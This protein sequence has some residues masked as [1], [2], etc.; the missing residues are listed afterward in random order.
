MKKVIIAVVLIVLAVTLA[1]ALMARPLAPAVSMGDLG[2]TEPDAATRVAGNLRARL[3]TGR[4][5]IERTIEAKKNARSFRMKTVLR[6]DPG[7]P[8]ITTTDVACPDRERFTTTIGE[9]E[10]QA[11]RIGEK[12]YIE[13]K[14]GSWG[15]EDTPA[16]GWA[17]CGDN[18]GEPAPWALM[19]EGRDPSTVLAK[20]LAN[21]E[22]SRG[23][24]V[25]T[26]A[27]NC[28]QWILSI[29]MPGGATHG[30]GADGL[31]YTVCIDRNHLPLAVIMGSGGMVTSYSD[32]NK[33]VEIDAP[34]M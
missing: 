14:D 4:A 1:A 25:S 27:G 23:A 30:H 33:P 6:M 34:K 31:N 11:V 10:F 17:P 3:T 32:W 8:L 5:E 16:A 29:K 13:Q 26:N 28:Q 24:F 18:P 7:Q 20:L 19:N 21:A 15:V 22:I 2:V 12:A 9:K